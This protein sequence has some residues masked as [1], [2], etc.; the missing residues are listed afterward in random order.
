MTKRVATTPRWRR[1]LPGGTPLLR[2]LKAIPILAGLA[3]SSGA[4]A[5][6]LVVGT[7]V[8]PFG[9]IDQ[10][11]GAPAGF[12]V[13]VMNAIAADAG[14]QIEFR[15]FDTFGDVLPALIA[16]QIDI[17]ATSLSIT[18]PRIE[19][20]VAFTAVYGRWTEALIVAAT[21][22]TPYRSID[23]LQ[24]KII[25]AGA[26]TTYIAGLQARPAG[27]FGEV[28]VLANDAGIDAVRTGA[29]DAYITNAALVAFEQA[30]GN[31][32]DVR[33]VGTDTYQPTFR[34]AG[35]IAVRHDDVELLGLIQRSL[36]KLIA[37]GTVAGLT[38]QWGLNPP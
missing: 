21:D 17:A 35:G 4:N 10:S 9:F 33:V 3:I 36:A 11:T 37:N 20:G 5:Q 7:A 14:L 38:Q 34:A 30:R 2:L 6:T 12:S 16:G 27:Y 18:A 28:R 15:H 25:A 24:G 29:V 13:D 19:M 22:Q 8:P 1:H 31:W 23:D 26:G 32:T